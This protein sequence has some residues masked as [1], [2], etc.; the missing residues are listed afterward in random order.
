MF[1]LG[2]VSRRQQL[3]EGE[4]VVVAITPISRGVVGP[5]AAT[6]VTVGALWAA[7]ATWQWAHHNVAWLSV[8]LVFPL[9]TVL[10]GRLWRWR[11]RKILVTSQRIAFSS[12]VTRRHTSSLELIDV[13]ATH[14]DQRWYERVAR[15][16]VV[17]VE[18]PAGTFVT[19]RVRR[20]D[21]LCRIVDHQRQQLNRYAEVHLDRASELSDALEAGLLSNEEYDVRWRHLFGPDSPRA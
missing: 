20:P 21:A 15:R 18:T 3:R 13:V 11:S 1:T 6:V 10:G 17:L 8:V 2:L 5:L 16:G 19:E 9:A 7:A 4:F 14:V 12:G